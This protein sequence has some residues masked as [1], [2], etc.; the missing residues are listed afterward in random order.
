MPAPAGDTI[1]ALASGP[2]P[3]AVAVLR[4]SGPA[5]REALALLTDAELPPRRLVRVTLR[6]AGEE[7][8]LD[9]GLA[10][11]FPG[12][13]SFTG[14]DAGELHVHGSRA[15]VEE[16]V[17][18]LCAH[19]AVRPAEPGE[20]TRRA[21]VNGKMDLVQ[22][23]GIA[24]LVQAE[25][26]HQRVQAVR[27]ARG[28]LSAVYEDWR[29]RTLEVLARAEAT[30]DFVDEDDVGEFGVDTDGL[31]ALAAEIRAHLDDGRRGERLR[32]G[33]AIAVLG[34][35]NAGKSSLVNML[36]RRDVAIVS[37]CAGT[38]RD[39]IEARLDLDGWPV[40]VADTAG[41]REAEDEIEREGIRRAR[42]WARAADVCVVL[43]D[44]DAGTPPEPPAW[45]ERAVLAWNK[46]DLAGGARAGPGELAISCRTGEGIDAL[47]ARLRAEVAR[48][49]GNPET[50]AHL[51]RSRHRDALATAAAAL[52]RAAEADPAELA[53]EELRAA[54]EALGRITGGVDVEDVLD[55]VFAAFCIGK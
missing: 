35:P 53:A 4:V 9:E 28:A 36:A 50:G 15:V 37:P 13:A 2:P 45:A 5:T 44:M 27:Q 17:E 12:P 54:A 30:L 42:D 40:T 23:E 47:L 7:A 52:E 14:E 39:V 29:A 26:R 16:V 10:V 19:P 18:A 34:P 41:L 11:F 25:T 24:D 38:T 22:A 8:P 55:L 48:G 31:R 3:A 33:F 49:A 46:A 51:T 32:E 43:G 6:R 20:F 21:F 1:V